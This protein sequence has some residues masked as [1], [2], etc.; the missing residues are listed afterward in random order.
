M[1]NYYKSLWARQV[2]I[3]AP[4]GEL[5][6]T[7]PSHWNNCKEQIFKVMKVLLAANCINKYL[8]YTIP[9]HIHTDMSNYQLGAAIIQNGK[10]IAYYSKKLTETQRNYTTTKKELPA[11]S[12]YVSKRILKNIAR[13]CS[14]YLH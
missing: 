8:D 1:V 11:I 4:L 2:H 3:L 7:K 9:V 6:G 14:T 13:Q 10:H 5:T 12:C